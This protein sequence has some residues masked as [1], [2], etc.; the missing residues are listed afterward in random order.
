MEESVLFQVTLRSL[1]GWRIGVGV[2]LTSLYDSGGQDGVQRWTGG[3]S[4]IPD[5]AV[6]SK[7]GVVTFFYGRS[8]NCPRFLRGIRGLLPDN[9]DNIVSKRSNYTF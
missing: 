6:A 2:Y 1:T 5:I 4:T 9:C 8:G 7:T 3:R